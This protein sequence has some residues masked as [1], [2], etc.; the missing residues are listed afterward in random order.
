MPRDRR[1]WLV[2][3]GVAVMVGG[4]VVEALADHQKA[5]YSER[6]EDERPDVLETGLWGWSRHPNYCGDSLVWD[7]AWLLRWPPRPPCGRCPRR[8]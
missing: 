1:N 3:A 5:K 2:P 6:A 4:A 8:P 7:G